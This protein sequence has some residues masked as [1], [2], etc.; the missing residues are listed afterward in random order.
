MQNTLALGRS[1][2][3]TDASIVFS[4][5]SN[6]RRFGI[7]EWYGKNFIHLSNKERRHLASLQITKSPQRKNLLCP[8]RSTDAL[9][10]NCTKEGGVCS[11]RFYE[12]ARRKVSK[13]SG[14]LGQLRATCPNRFQ[15]ESLVYRWVSEV[16]LGVQESSV[17]GEV[18]FLKRSSDD[19]DPDSEKSVGKID[20]VLI[21]PGSDPLRWCALEIQTVY[22]SG[23]G[24]VNE[25]RHI[26][27]SKGVKIPFPFA[28]RRPDYRSSGPKR[29][30]PQ[31]QTKV[32]TLRRWGKKMAVVVDRSFFNALGK[33]DSVEDI[34]NCDIAWFVV[35]Y[36]E[37]VEPVR[38]T[39]D[40]VRFTTLER[41]VEGLTGGVPVTLGEFEK[42]IKKK[43]ASL[44][45]IVTKPDLVQ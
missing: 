39:R 17:I 2:S 33:M 1:P 21:V 31:L 42:R 38:V 15:Q 36:D 6:R 25:Y 4:K 16:V 40:F 29:L 9:I 10:V 8:F 12:E 19:E 20:N 41:A 7:G 32:P 34:S 14:E 35:G 45:P 43:A 18:G 30:M 24:M 44:P 5:M 22:F 28:A 13:V 23:K 26:F 27:E 11:I 3:T 37:K